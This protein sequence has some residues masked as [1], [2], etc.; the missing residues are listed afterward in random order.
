MSSSKSCPIWASTISVVSPPTPA[1]PER[2][3]LRHLPR[4]AGLSPVP[5]TLHKLIPHHLHPQAGGQHFR[6]PAGISALLLLSEL[7]TGFAALFT[8]LSRSSSHSRGTDPVASSTSLPTF[9]SSCFL[10]AWQLQPN[11]LIRMVL[12]SPQL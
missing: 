2:L 3:M 4:K 1:P 6:R 9:E 5:M 7:S 8:S 11:T 12:S 10:T